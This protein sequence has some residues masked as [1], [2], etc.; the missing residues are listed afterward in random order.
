M[1]VLGG[2]KDRMALVENKDLLSMAKIGRAS[3]PIDLMSYEPEDE[4]PSIFFL[5]E[6]PRQSILTVFN[7]TKNT[8]SHT[9]D[10]AQLGLT[11]EHSYTATDVLNS[12]A[13]VDLVGDSLKI[14]KQIPESVRVIKIVDNNVPAAAPRVNVQV[15]KDAK[16]G[17]TI[18]LSAEAQAE[19]VPAVEYRWDFGDGTGATGAK[20]RHAYTKPDNFAVTLTVEGVDGVP[21]IQNSSV[22]VS[23]LLYA[24]PKLTDNR[25][26][27]EP[28]D[29]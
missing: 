29:H 24:Y 17:E 4:Q 10:L 16:T 28:A 6:G 8:R 11:A 1:V 5:R 20:A 12:A 13:T 14:Q 9:F 22:R 19:E 23:G 18:E 3:K 27:R 25:R 2:E 26:F 21:A 7:W 15:P